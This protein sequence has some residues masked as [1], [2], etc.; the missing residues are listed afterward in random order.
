MG[1]GFLI[2]VYAFATIARFS[3]RHRCL[4]LSKISNSLECLHYVYQ[5]NAPSTCK[6]SPDDRTTGQMYWNAWRWLFTTWRCKCT[7]RQPERCKQ[8]LE[9]TANFWYSS[10][11]TWG[12]RQRSTTQRQDHFVALQARRH[13]FWTATSLRNDLLNASEVNVS[14]QTIRNRLHNAGLNSRRA[15]VRVPLTVRHRRERLDW[16]EDHVTWTQNDWV[17]VLFTDESRY[18]L[19]FTDRRHRVWRRQRE[20]FHDANISEHDRY[21]GGSIMV[22]VESAGME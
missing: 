1:N 17:Q 8:G 14:T 15:C 6:A 16:A 3:L 20:R 11:P 5:H 13:P 7:K 21:G 18:C 2:T 4:I 19:D 12:G 22:R 10:T 9:P